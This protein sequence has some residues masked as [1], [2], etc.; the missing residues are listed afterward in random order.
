MVDDVVAVDSPRHENE[1]VWGGPAW[2][3]NQG[4]MVFFLF[5]F[6]DFVKLI[7]NADILKKVI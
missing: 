4:Q 5:N 7:F 1:R 2:F 6:K 3:T